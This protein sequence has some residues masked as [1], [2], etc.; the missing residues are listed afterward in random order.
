[1]VVVM[2]FLVKSEGNPLNMQHVQHRPKPWSDERLAL[3]H[4]YSSAAV[5]IHAILQEEVVV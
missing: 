2:V 4:P 1:M 3:C 5:Y